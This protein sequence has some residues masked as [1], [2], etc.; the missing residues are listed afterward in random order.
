MQ[1]AILNA[2]SPDYPWADRFHYFSTVDSTNNYLKRQSVSCWQQLTP[3]P[4]ITH[5]F[6][7]VS[8]SSSTRMPESF[9]FSQTRSLVHL[10]PG[11]TPAASSKASHMAVPTAQVRCISLELTAPRWLPP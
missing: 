8:F 5:S 4:I 11:L 2:L 10:I 3:M 7:R 1:D 9:R 6:P